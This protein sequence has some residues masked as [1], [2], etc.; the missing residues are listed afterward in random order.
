[1]LS[2]IEKCTLSNLNISGLRSKKYAWVG[3]TI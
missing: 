2:E 1:M 3:R